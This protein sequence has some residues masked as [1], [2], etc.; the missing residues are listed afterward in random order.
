MDLENQFDIHYV[1][2]NRVLIEILRI[3][4]KICLEIGEF[5]FLWFNTWFFERSWYTNNFEI[6]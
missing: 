5:C 3:N 6:S 4:N 2:C 1:I